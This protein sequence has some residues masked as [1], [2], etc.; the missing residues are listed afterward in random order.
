MSTATREPE[1]VS[2]NPERATQNPEP[3]TRNP[4]RGTRNPPGCYCIDLPL[5]D[6]HDAWDMQIAIVNAKKQGILAADVILLLE[7]FPVFTLG[8]RG[9]LEHLTVSKS[10]LETSNIDVV[11]VERGG[12]ITYH[13]PG[14][15]VVYP[16]LDLN[17]RRLGITDLVSGM[18]EIMIRTARDFGVQAGCNPKNRG[19]W[20]G[21]QKLG[22]IGIAVRRGISYHGFAFNVHPSLTHFDWI[23]PCGL[24]DIG[25]TSLKK[26]LGTVISIGDVRLAITHHMEK[27]F[28]LE[29]NQI[30]R[31][32]LNELIQ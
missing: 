11:H 15:I 10:F 13:G 2:R 28:D 18:E 8:R 4:Q 5:T 27:V 32:R 9:G 21:N 16:I 7:H 14:Q 22:S 23:H 12:N 6:Y 30:T 3:A 25:V 17:R 31:D 29:L 24:T 1:F 20:V 26:E 19:V